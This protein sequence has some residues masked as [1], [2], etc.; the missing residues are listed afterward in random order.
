MPPSS[1]GPGLGILIP[2][3]AVRVRLGVRKGT[4][5]KVSSFFIKKYTFCKQLCYF[6]V[7]RY[8]V[9]LF[10]I[11]S[12][13]AVFADVN[14]LPNLVDPRDK[15]VYKTVQIGDQR[16]MA[17]NLRFKLKG[18]FCYNKSES[19]CDEYGRL[20]TWAAS[21]RLVDFYNST[22][23]KD[24]VKK[25]HDV[26]PKGWRVPTNKD[27]KKLKYYVSKKG[28]SDGVGLSLKSK[29]G[30]EREL[31]LPA[32]SDEFGFN[33]IPAGEF[34][35]VGEFMDRGSSTQFWASNEYDAYGAY[36]WRL[37]YDS[38]T[39]DKVYDAKD[40]AV[41][42]RCVEEKY[43]KP[44][45]PPPPPVVVKPEVVKVQ[46]KEILTIHVGDQVWMA[47][48]LDV[49]VPGS[50]CY[51][52]DKAAC[53]KYGRLYTW[54]AAMKFSDEYLQV[55]ARDSVR[56]IHKG[57]CPNGWHIPSIYDFDRLNAFIQDIDDAV[58]VG[59]NLKARDVWPETENSMPGENGFGFKALPS[60]YRPDMMSFVGM[61]S[62]TG[63]WSTAEKD[64]VTA[65]YWSL[66]HDSDDLLRD[67]VGKIAA[68]P[69]RCLMDPPGIDEIY[70]STALYDSRDENRYKTVEIGGK[71]WMAENLRFAAP[72]SFCY[73]DKDIRCR[74]YGR[75]YPWHV[76]M[77]LPDDFITNPVE[78]AIA[79]E[80]QGICPSGWHV[81]SLAE[82]NK[83][84]ADIVAMGKGSVA[85]ALKIR[86]GWVRGGAPISEASGFNAIP[87]GARY[88]DGEFMELGTSA[89]FWEASG[90]GDTGAAYWNLINSKDDV[91]RAEDFE[92]TAFSLRCVQNAPVDST[93]AAAGNATAGG[94]G[95]APAAAASAP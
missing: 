80:H 35:Y 67:S 30:W 91:M 11:A 79:V 66:R 7:M 8:F 49:E 10:L 5:R 62:L 1:S 13:S 88:N 59:T 34:H 74:S 22:L 69:V 51:G 18:T 81:P 75:L 12:V 19:N 83:M 42:V 58:G 63:F 61:D 95:A 54:A 53:K 72:G 85:A 16:W 71:R 77:R 64:S 32:G 23:A 33:A 15:Q 65:F 86:E 28:K 17:E 14:P 47:K 31:R 68:F 84:L 50:Y 39:F 94:D 41:S 44:I 48:N 25:V 40:N 76:A 46:N 29:E 43:Y 2:A 70:D 57:I 4:H 6:Y 21:M 3:T 26:C 37:T 87:A 27:W 60:G 56:R 45:E 89:Y 82:W 20:Y 9:P 78:G 55:S 93:K 92:N 36:F 73:E 52:D 90:G 38:R 24:A